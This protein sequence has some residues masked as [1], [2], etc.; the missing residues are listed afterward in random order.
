M[1]SALSGIDDGGVETR[2]DDLDF[3]QFV[4]KAGSEAEDE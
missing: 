1:V 4:P 2:E 3:G